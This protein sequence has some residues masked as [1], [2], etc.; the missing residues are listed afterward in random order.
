V[1]ECP[2]EGWPAA[3]RY[4]AAITHSNKPL[5]ELWCSTPDSL[6]SALRPYL[7]MP[8]ITAVITTPDLPTSRSNEQE[9]G[10]V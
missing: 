1:P 10:N 5:A 9:T 3:T 4:T 2:A 8:G 6:V 7:A